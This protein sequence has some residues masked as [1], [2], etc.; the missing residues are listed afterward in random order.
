MVAARR[1]RPAAALLGVAVT[2]LGL[3][4]LAGPARGV[5]LASG[6]AAR[7]LD[8][9]A[10]VTDRALLRAPIRG[11]HPKCGVLPSRSGTGDDTPDGLLPFRAAPQ[12]PHHLRHGA[13]SAPESSA[14]RPRPLRGQ[15]QSPR[16]PPL[17][18]TA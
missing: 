10:A 2:L 18:P 5:A 16:A 12:P 14:L 9:S 7:G 11:V 13:Q 4:A 1:P 17:H 6:E 8:Q 15:P 3:F